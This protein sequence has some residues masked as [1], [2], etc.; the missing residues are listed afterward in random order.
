MI[1]IDKTTVCHLGKA[2]FVI[3]GLSRGHFGVEAYL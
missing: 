2:Q 3:N 1:I